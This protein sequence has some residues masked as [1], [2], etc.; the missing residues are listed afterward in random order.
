MLI[1]IALPICYAFLL[2]GE[3][4]ALVDTGRPQDFAAIENALR[5]HGVALDDLPLILHTHG[6]WDHCGSTA[7]LRQHTRARIAIHAADA[8]MMRCGN[9]GT[10]RPTSLLA[11][12]FKPILDRTCPGA[13]PDFLIE[14]EIDLAEFGVPAQVIF[15]PGHTAGSISV[16]T[17]EGDAVV[18]DLVMGGYFGGWLRPHQPGLHYFADNLDLLRASIRKLLALAPRKIYPAHGGPLDPADVARWVETI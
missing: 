4:P 15:T 12:L 9:N 10:L 7:Q 13:E 1:P 2:K 18:G 17:R 6:H 8:P 11:R 3:R 5:E 16:L 14:D